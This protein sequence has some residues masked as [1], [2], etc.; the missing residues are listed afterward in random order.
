MRRGD[1]ARQDPGPTFKRIGD[2]LCCEF[3]LRNE[4]LGVNQLPNHAVQEGFCLDF[5][6]PFVAIFQPLRLCDSADCA[7]A[8]AGSLDRKRASN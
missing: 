2:C 7:A 3:S 6:M 5:V 8:G 1:S 4:H